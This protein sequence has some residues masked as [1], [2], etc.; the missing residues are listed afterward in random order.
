M[1][2]EVRKSNSSYRILVD[3]GY[4]VCTYFR[5]DKETAIDFANKLHT[6][7][8]TL[9]ATMDEDVLPMVLDMYLNY[10]DYLHTKRQ[11]NPIQVANTIETEYTKK[12]NEAFGWC[13][14]V[15]Q[16]LENKPVDEYTVHDYKNIDEYHALKKQYM[17][18]VKNI[19]VSHVDTTEIN[20]LAHK[21]LEML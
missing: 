14:K 7:Y 3:Y 11:I 2:T 5:N 6:I 8:N 17:L 12:S 4:D 21:I 13:T 9:A 19:E 20:E 1:R 16:D 10:I 15:R 18:P